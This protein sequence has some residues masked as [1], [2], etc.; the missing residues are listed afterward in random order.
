MRS[1]VVLVVLLAACVSESDGGSG[2]PTPSG[3]PGDQAR[4]WNNQLFPQ[5]TGAFHIVL[6]A[7]PSESSMDAVIGVSSGPANSISELGPVV[8][9]SSA[10]TLDVRNGSTYDSDA[11]FAYHPERT[12]QIRME[13]DLARQRYDVAVEEDGANTTWIANGYAFPTEQ[14]TV[15]QLDNLAT[16]VA[17]PTGTLEQFG[18]EANPSR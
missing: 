4:G 3:H 17:S 5:Q 2:R 9:F 16:F 12:Y 11:A 18:L 10:G 6:A 15:S 7:I 8:R 14:A 1:A 13:I